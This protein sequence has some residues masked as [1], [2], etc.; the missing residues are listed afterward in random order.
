MAESG[1]MRSK[2]VGVTP[3]RAV[4]F[5]CAVLLGATS[6]EWFIYTF[7]MWEMVENLSVDGDPTGGMLGDEV[8]FVELTSWQNPDLGSDRGIVRH[9]IVSGVTF[10][11]APLS[12]DPAVDPLEDGIPD[13]FAF[14]SSVD[15]YLE[16]VVDGTPRRELVA[17]ITAGDPQLALGV[18][19]VTLSLTGIDLLGFVDVEGGFGIAIEAAGVLPPDRVVFTA[20]IVY[21]VTVDVY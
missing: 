15:I 16:A 5:L 4:L 17:F 6:C 20:Y 10:E 21:E 18:A 7:E 14:V 12:T 11:I 8:G 9:I 3:A 1:A 19:S 2:G 13:D